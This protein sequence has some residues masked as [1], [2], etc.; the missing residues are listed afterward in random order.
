[1]VVNDTLYM[2]ELF[3]F[4]NPIFMVLYTCA[5]YYF[6]SK[7]KK[8]PN[9][10]LNVFLSVVAVLA[11]ISVS[12]FVYKGMHGITF[13][14]SNLYATISGGG[15][16]QSMVGLSFPL[17]AV[18]I[19]IK[20]INA[21]A[22][23]SKTL[24][25]LMS[26][27]I[28]FADIFVNQG[29]I[30]YVIE[31][32]ML[33]YYSFSLVRKFS[34]TND[35]LNLIKIILAVLSSLICIFMLFCVAYNYSATF[36]KRV[37][38]MN[39]NIVSYVSSDSSVANSKYLANTSIGLRALYYSTSIK[40]FKEY[41]S[42]FLFGCGYKENILNV[43]ECSRLLVKNNSKL[44]DDIYVIQTGVHPH[45]EF[46]NY[47]FKGGVVASSCLIM[48]FIM[49]FYEARNLTYYNMIFMR[50]LVVGFLIGS[51]FEYLISRQLTIIIFFTLVAIFLIN[52]PIVE[53]DN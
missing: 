38:D 46:I 29:R 24:L 8:Y 30:G 27:V 42:V 18:I 49:L 50:I 15:Y 3:A 48:F 25:A 22:K 26:I 7:N 13:I 51:M 34:Y 47:L 37:S 19:L 21:K 43:S 1:M 23:M 6:L 4:S 12:F 52:Y 11:F 39:N 40:I 9:I 10:L 20:A 32:F 14:I 31:F 33:F 41:P 44:K 16:I 45:N 17:S 28:I 36:H 2:K 53:R 5:L 35:K